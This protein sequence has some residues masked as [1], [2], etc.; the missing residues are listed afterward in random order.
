LT[1]CS[2]TIEKSSGGLPPIL[3]AEQTDAPLARGP[4][5]LTIASSYLGIFV[6]AP[7]FD[8]LWIGDLTRFGV[9]S[10]IG[11]AVV[12]AL[13][14]YGLL[15]LVPALLGFRYRQS[16]GIVASSTFGTLGS[17]WITGVAVGLANILWYAVAI[18]YAVDSTLLGLHSCGLI[19]TASLRA[20]DLGPMVVKS[21]VYLSTALFW[22]YITGMAGLLRLPG[23]IVALMRVYA[24]IALLLLTGVAVC[25]LPNLGSYRLA[26]AVSIAANEGLNQ[27]WPGH[28]SSLQVM[29]GF[30]A[31]AG[32][33]SVDWGARLERRRDILWGGLASIVLVASVTSV[34][35]LVVVA[36]AVARLV[37]DGATPTA[38]AINASPLSFR[39]AVVHGI[40]GVPG[41]AILILFGLASLAP[42]CYSVWVYGQRLSTHW[43]RLRQSGWTWSGGLI[44]FVLGATSC[45]NRLDLVYSAMGDIFAPVVG[46]IVGNWVRLRG[47]CSG[48]R[49]GINPSAVI[50][51]GAGAL[52][53][54]ILDVFRVFNREYSD[55][56]QP[57]SVCG[58]LTSAVAFGLLTRMESPAPSLAPTAD[59]PVHS[60][61]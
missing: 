7:F 42:A 33:V 38:S 54:M 47:K 28:G 49:R 6:W 52:V 61:D 10:L 3:R 58:F 11:R 37:S 51:W 32:L 9:D 17:E 1:D 46:V 55:W 14:C 16:V 12:G 21:P 18:D 48:F 25:L 20:W 40:G 4:W 8:S 50:A 36:G 31:M 57:T 23:V 44:A 5:Y 56:C 60:N 34:L 30:F 39:W 22:I 27:R 19:D 43:P 2:E 13:L 15:F 35:S 53:G 41:G 59:D 24:P 45:V 26:D 29:T